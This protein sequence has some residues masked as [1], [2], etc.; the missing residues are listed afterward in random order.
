MII[1]WIVLI[2]QLIQ[3]LCSS[4]GRTKQLLHKELKWR[5]DEGKEEWKRIRRMPEWAK[6]L[7]ICFVW[8]CIRHSDLAAYSQW[9]MD[10]AAWGAA[11]H[12]VTVQHDWVTITSVCAVIHTIH[13][14]T[15][16][17]TPYSI[18]KPHP[19]LYPKLYSILKPRWG[20]RI[21]QA[22]L[23]HHL[24]IREFCLGPALQ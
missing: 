6:R 24:L 15:L 7:S 20:L 2:S 18:P 11:V 13:L 10:R 17:A 3:L 4:A 22:W 19:V 8:R 16:T 21:T 12:G 5:E 23:S 14:L 1:Y 9:P